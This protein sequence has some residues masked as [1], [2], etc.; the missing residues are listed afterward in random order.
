M[1][2]WYLNSDTDTDIDSDWYL[3]RYLFILW[4]LPLITVLRAAEFCQFRSFCVL[5]GS[6][7]IA[8]KSGETY[9]M[10]FVANFMENTTVKKN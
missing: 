2:D 8:L 5:Q 6:G 9:D 1:F 7:V 3:N 10:D 4:T